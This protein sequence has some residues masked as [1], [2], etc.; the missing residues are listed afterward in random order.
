M[1]FGK[2]LAHHHFV[3]VPCGQLRGG[4]GRILFMILIL[5]YNCLSQQRKLK[6]YHCTIINY[7]EWKKFLVL[8]VF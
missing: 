5:W 4:G 1:S 3:L 8:I 6:K 2:L 7:N